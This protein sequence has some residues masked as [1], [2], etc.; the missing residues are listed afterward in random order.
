MGTSFLLTQ[1]D[2]TFLS[3]WDSVMGNSGNCEQLSK[4]LLRVALLRAKRP[5]CTNIHP[6][7]VERWSWVSAA[8]HLQGA[9]AGLLSTLT[10]LPVQPQDRQHTQVLRWRAETGCRPHAHNCILWPR[11]LRIVLRARDTG[12]RKYLTPAPRGSCP[13]R[14]AGLGV[15]LK[16][17]RKGHEERLPTHRTLGQYHFQ[18]SAL[19]RPRIRMT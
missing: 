2:L 1:E 6:S 18:C 7:L 3:S 12:L 14:S 9:S 17:Q 4:K 13:C 10:W 19:K 16:E 11:G 8:P 5:T 15:L